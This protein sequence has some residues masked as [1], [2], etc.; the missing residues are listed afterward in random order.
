MIN[1]LLLYFKQQQ[2][3]RLNTSPMNAQSTAVV[4]DIYFISKHNF[5]FKL[6]W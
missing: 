4:M 5:V 3:H 2:R 1:E 6:R